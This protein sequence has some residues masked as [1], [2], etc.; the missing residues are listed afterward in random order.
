II[1]ICLRNRESRRYR[2]RTIELERIPNKSQLLPREKLDAFPV[3]VFKLENKVVVVQSVTIEN[4]E[5]EKNCTSSIEKND[6]RI[7]TNE[8]S[9]DTATDN[10][11][12]NNTTN[13]TPTANHEQSGPSSETRDVSE[14]KQAREEGL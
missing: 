1:I 10:G 6:S 14:E 8:N 5:N 9:N 12:I 11:Q 2:T 3:I 4:G 7:Y 13:T